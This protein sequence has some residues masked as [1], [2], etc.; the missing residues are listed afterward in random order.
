MNEIFK[1]KN[2]FEKLIEI[3]DALRS[4]KGCPWDREQ[5]E[6]TIV[7]YF[8]EEVYEA[9]D[10][11]V[12]GDPQSLKEELGDVLMEVVFLT[13]IYKEKNEFT[14]DD[15][16]EGINHKMIRRHPHVFGPVR[17][18]NSS[19]VRDEWNLHKK[20]EKDRNSVLEGMANH[21]PSLLKAFQMGQRVSLYGFDWES[22]LDVLGKVR[23][24][25]DELERALQADN[26]EGVAEEIG[27]LLFSLANFSRHVDVNPEIALRQTNDKFSQRF[28]Y[29]EERLRE[30][31]EEI[32]KVSLAELDILWEEA[33]EKLDLGKA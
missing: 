17:I 12:S 29:I 25:L 26:R 28:R 27:D 1:T 22:S 11:V 32:G 33:K 13:R 2:A 18:E 31:G 20:N 7:N 8:L 21:L 6:H 3:M 10:A 24:E 15:V 9:V 14:I 5:D 16:L 30:R 4:E 19:Q 23:E